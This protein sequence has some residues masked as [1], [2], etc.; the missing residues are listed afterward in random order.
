M[1]DNS[2]S[3]DDFQII[4]MNYKLKK[5]KNRKKRGQY[6]KND[7]FETLDNTTK[8]EQ[9]GAT[10][11]LPSF[12]SENVVEPFEL[13]P[14]EFPPYTDDDYDG[15]D[16]VDDTGAKVDFQYDPREWLIALIEW[17]YYYLNI[18]NNY[19]ASKIVN[20]LSEKTGQESDVKLVRNY[21]A[22]TEAIAAGCYVVYNWFFIIY[23]NRTS[24]PP[25][26]LFDVDF[27]QIYNNADIDNILK[28][29]EANRRTEKLST[30][31]QI[32]F[33]FLAI[34][35]Y[36]FEYPFTVL[37]FLNMFVIEILPKYTEKKF[38][39]SFLFVYLFYQSCLFLK[40]SALVV[41]KLFI[42]SLLFKFDPSS[43]II[44]IAIIGLWFKDFILA[45]MKI[46]DKLK[47]AEPGGP[48]VQPP[49]PSAIALEC[50]GTFF[51]KL[52]KLFIL[53]I[54]GIPATTLA[55]VTYFLAYSFFGIFIY[56]GFNTKTFHD[57]D[58]YVKIPLEPYIPDIC[59]GYHWYDFLYE[60]FNIVMMFFD[61]LQGKLFTITFML[62]YAISCYDYSANITPDTKNLKNGL[63]GI[64]IGLIITL[65]SMV[66]SYFF[67]KMKGIPEE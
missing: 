2:F 16:N 12:S 39:A 33:V 65:L 67:E 56:K 14:L 5:I 15:I 13:P 60:I 32:Y 29:I 66:G 6:K 20:I 10:S 48:P 38:P 30:R 36:F 22:W 44:Y 51:W 37:H 55:V 24:D 11:F 42:N 59:D 19:W 53:I 50:L 49:P 43:I 8:P 9:D 31:E 47:P 58:S 64:N 1:K 7:L 4:N 28:D 63:L 52:L 25:I 18:F 3:K 23:Y 46:L 62:L 26:K 57:I 34:V 21:I 17:I 35:K 40:N 41:K 27:L 54:I 61:T 45:F